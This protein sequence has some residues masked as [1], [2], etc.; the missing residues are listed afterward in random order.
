MFCE[1]MNSDIAVSVDNITKSYRL[2]S[3]NT[4]RVK[5]TFHP[6]RKKYHHTFTALNQVS[7]EIKQGRALGIIGRNGSGKSTLLQIASGILMP[8]AGS[9]VTRGTTA[10]LLELGSGFN[11]EY[12]GRENVYLNGRLLGLSRKEIDAIFE[13]IVD[14][15]EI[16]E[17]LDQPVKTYS[18]GMYVRLAF[19]V[20]V[21]VNPDILIIDEALSVGDVFFQQKCF[22]RMREIISKGTTCLFVSHDTAAIQNLCDEAILLNRGNVEFYGDP[23]EAVSLYYSTI[24]QKKVKADNGLEREEEYPSEKM[25]SV[26]SVKDKIITNNIIGKK[27]KRFYPNGKN[28]LKILA[29]RLTDKEGKDVSQ[30]QMMEPLVFQILLAADGDVDEPNCGLDFFDRFGNLIFS[31]GLAQQKI[32]LPFMQKGQEIVVTFEITFSVQPG[33]YTYSLGAGEPSS[34]FNPNVGYVHERVEQLGPIIVSYDKTECSPFY[35]IAMLP[36]VVRLHLL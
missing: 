28:A 20:Q 5:E 6:F 15:A 16:G 21:C 32:S 2:Y 33:E 17:F 4:D 27:A 8:T 7:F 26:S 12:T 24:G 10:A 30:V 34:G 31:T 35:G 3:S 19:A 36:T 25:E 29:G 1:T 18:S 23:D 9:V 14:F 13:D 22:A 11:P